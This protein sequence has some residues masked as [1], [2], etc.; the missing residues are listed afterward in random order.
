MANKTFNLKH[1]EGFLC[2][3][4]YSWRVTVLHYHGMINVTEGNHKNNISTIY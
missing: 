1:S 2:D 4:Y 3:I